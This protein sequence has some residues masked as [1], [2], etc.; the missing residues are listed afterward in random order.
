MLRIW[1]TVWIFIAAACAPASAQNF[2]LGVTATTN[3]VS[4]S[5]PVIFTINLTNENGAAGVFVTNSVAG[6]SAF[7][8][9]DA[10]TTVGSRV[11]NSSSVLFSLGSL[12]DGIGSI[13]QMTVTVRPT[14]IGAFTNDVV[15]VASVG[16]NKTSTNIVV[17][18]TPPVSDMAVSLKAPTLPVLVGDQITYSAM[19]TNLGTNSV[20]NVVLTNGDFSSMK[21]ISL[22]PTNQA[23]TLT[24]GLLILN[25]GT[26]TNRA[27]KTFTFT[28]QPTNAGTLA[29]A[30]SILATNILEPNL[31][32]NVASTN[33][34]IEP[35]VTG[36]LVAVNASEMTYNPQTGLMEQTVNLSN[37]GSNA[38]AAARVIVAGLTNRLYNAVGTNNG[39]P[40][41]V[42]N[43]PLA[44][45]ANVNLL[46][47]YFIP[48]RLP[49]TVPNSNYTAVAVSL[50]DLAVGAV[51]VPVT[52]ITNLGAAGILIEFPAITNRSYTVFYSSDTSFTN[53][54]TAQPSIV[55]PADRVQWIDNGP[56]KTVSHP[57]STNS[58]RFYRV[59]LNP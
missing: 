53:G 18:V 55:A 14:T 35:L 38:V 12:F 36:D 20:A 6:T 11:I 8:I 46:M 56:P 41:V 43:A 7:Q 57:S 21:L 17:Q 39:N 19:V 42:F 1:A 16:T 45:G 10:T 48:T 15:V 47:E 2:G 29:L 37:V 40:F 52:L 13:A 32:N 50:T 3:S 34:T 26:F 33:I 4:V 28:T 23:Y 25:A 44:A 49:I 5:S 58:S 27:S 24:N 31:S 59:L 51:G 9:T 22:S 30:A 54:L